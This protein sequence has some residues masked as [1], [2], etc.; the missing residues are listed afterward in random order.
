MT[1]VPYARLSVISNTFLQSTVRRNVPAARRAHQR[2]FGGDQGGKPYI[3]WKGMCGKGANELANMWAGG[4]L[5]KDT[6]LQ[7]LTVDF[8][9][10]RDSRLCRKSDVASLQVDGCDSSEH[11]EVCAT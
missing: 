7:A 6:A 4:A 2:T 9:R 3:G 5:P 10:P 8:P 11:Q 1:W